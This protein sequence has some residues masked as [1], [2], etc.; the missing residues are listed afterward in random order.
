MV[1]PKCSVPLWIFCEQ[2]DTPRR[3]LK[4]KYVLF[5]VEVFSRNA[6]HNSVETFSQG[7]SQV[8]DDVQPG[9]EVAEATVKEIAL[10]RVSTHG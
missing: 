9:A 1:L 5:T 2:K 8:A 6:V 7:R 3:I 10:L 4:K